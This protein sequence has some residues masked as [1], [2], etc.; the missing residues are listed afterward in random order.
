MAGGPGWVRFGIGVNTDSKFLIGRIVCMV[1]RIVMKADNGD[2]WMGG[3][4]GSLTY[5][6]VQSFVLTIAC[7]N[8]V[9][10]AN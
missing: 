3:D 10:H 5:T 4:V 8:P 1:A 9:P 7:E 6:Y 2:A